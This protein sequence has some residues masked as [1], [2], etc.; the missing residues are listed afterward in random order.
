ME[1]DVE[2]LAH[3]AQRVLRRDRVLHDRGDFCAAVHHSLLS[4]GQT[5]SKAAKSIAE[6]QRRNKRVLAGVLLGSE[7]LIETSFD[8]ERSLSSR[9]ASKDADR[10]QESGDELCIPRRMDQFVP[11]S[12]QASRQEMIWA[13]IDTDTNRML[14]EELRKGRERVKRAAQ[15]LRSNEG[16]L[17]LK[18]CEDY[19]QQVKSKK[20]CYAFSRVSAFSEGHRFELSKA[21]SI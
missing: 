6:V 14:L 11:A 2:L 3:L 19:S 10:T 13:G 16:H 4:L 12:D 20:I 7:E 8:L 9:L 5:V 1:W 15:D 18:H 17:D 21:E